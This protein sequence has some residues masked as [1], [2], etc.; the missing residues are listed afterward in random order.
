MSCASVASP[1]MVAG[2]RM[3][4]SKTNSE[5]EL[6]NDELALVVGGRESP[7]E[8]LKDANWAFARGDIFGGMALLGQLPTGGGGGWI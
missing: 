7:R 5:R 6:T 2:W 8:L 1:A 4:M 3:I